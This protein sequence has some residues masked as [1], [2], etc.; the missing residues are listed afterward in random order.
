MTLCVCSAFS[1]NTTIT[2]ADVKLLRAGVLTIYPAYFL[3]WAPE[4][5]EAEFVY[6]KRLRG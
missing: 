6:L 4:R 1:H 2:Y 3:P 5:G